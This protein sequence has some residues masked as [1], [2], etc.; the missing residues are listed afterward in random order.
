MA[1]FSLFGALALTLLVHTHHLLQ[2]SLGCRC[3]NCVITVSV[4]AGNARSNALIFALMTNT[5]FLLSRE[6]SLMSVENSSYL[7]L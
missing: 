7:W 1:V 5:D 2:Y 3:Q 6:S 4:R